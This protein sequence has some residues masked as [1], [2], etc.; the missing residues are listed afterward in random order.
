MLELI[1]N[2]NVITTGRPSGIDEILSATTRKN[3]SF[4]AYPLK[5]NIVVTIR[6]RIAVNI[7][8]CFVNFCILICKG[9][10]V[11]SVSNTSFAMFP[12]SVNEDVDTTIPLARPLMTEVPK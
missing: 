10:I 11:S 2:D 7:P 6:A 8:I 12:I 9:V 1:D 4:A 3:I 5:Y